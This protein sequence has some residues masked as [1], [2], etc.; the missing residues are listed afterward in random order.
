VFTE[1]TRPGAVVVPGLHTEEGYNDDGLTID[2]G[3]GEQVN[4]APYEESTVHIFARAVDTEE[5][6]QRLRAFD[7][8]L[9]ERDQI[10][11][12]RDQLHQR[13]DNAVTITPVVATNSDVEIG[14]ENIHANRDDLPRSNDPK[15]GTRG[16]RWGAISVILLIVVVIA[17]TLALL[18]QPEPTP[19]Q[20]L[21]ELISSASSD[22]GVAL[23]DRSTSQNRALQWLAGSPNLASYTDQEKIQRYALATIYYATKGDTWYKHDYWLSDEDVC[24]KWYQLAECT[25]DGPVS[26]IGLSNNNLQGVIPPEIG[27]LSD[28]LGKFAVDENFVKLCVTQSGD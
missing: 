1:E 9:R 21:I 25:S 28:S 19:P 16:R 4:N 14:E 27:L 8:A 22:S 26:A 6:N 5:E 15:C 2:E 12:E 11:H 23:A 18:L 24:G 17:V 13:L 20:D 10:R 7:Q 3:C